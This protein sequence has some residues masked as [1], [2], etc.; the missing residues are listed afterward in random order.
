MGILVASFVAVKYV[1]GHTICWYRVYYESEVTAMY[2]MFLHS[3]HST[4]E[5]MIFALFWSIIS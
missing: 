3:A 2:F 4:A 5:K 1:L